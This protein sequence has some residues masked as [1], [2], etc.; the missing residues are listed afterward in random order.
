MRLKTDIERKVDLRKHKQTGDNREAIFAVS[1]IWRVTSAGTTLK[2]KVASRSPFSGR[3]PKRRSKLWNRWEFSHSM[4]ATLIREFA[5]LLMCPVWICFSIRHFVSRW[6]TLV[7]CPPRARGCCPRVP[8]TLCAG[9][10][11]PGVRVHL[12][13]ARRGHRD[14]RSSDPETGQRLLVTSASCFERVY[15]FERSSVRRI[16]NPNQRHKTCFVVR[17]SM[18][19]APVAV[20]SGSSFLVQSGLRNNQPMMKGL[21]YSP[22]RKIRACHP[23]FFT[24]WFPLNPSKEN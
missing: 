2:S 15:A 11:I 22:T 6:A 18:R 12:V 16:R 21:T 8:Q 10:R 19:M 13:P 3:G 14:H 20:H 7:P 5:C 17:M 4:Q 1:W 24:K 23:S 9:P